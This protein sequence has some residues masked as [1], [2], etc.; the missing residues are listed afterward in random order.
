MAQPQTYRHLVAGST[1]IKPSGEILT[2]AGP[3]GGMGY[4]VT[5]K[6]DEITALDF[7]AKAPTAQVEKETPET[8]GAPELLKPVDPAIAVAKEDAASNT[9][10]QVDPK[11]VAAQAKIADMIAASAPAAT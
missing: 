3:K 4:Y 7:L 5:D 2:F 1:F 6:E 10:R 9:A 8:I 11:V